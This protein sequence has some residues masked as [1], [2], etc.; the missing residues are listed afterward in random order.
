MSLRKSIGSALSE[1]ARGTNAGPVETRHSVQAPPAVQPTPLLWLTVLSLDA[2]TVAALWQRLFA[3]A[4]RVQ[5]AAGVTALLALVV[6]LIYVADRALD[7]LKV[8]ARG[9]EAARHIFYRRHLWAFAVPFCAGLSLAAWMALMQLD[10]RTFRHGVILLL[11]VGAYLFAVHKLA[12]GRNWLPKEMLVGV[13]FALGTCFPVWERMPKGLPLLA[14]YLIFT[15]LCWMNCAAIEFEEWKRL[16]HQ[17][18]GTPHPWTVWMGRHFAVL[19]L[20]IGASALSLL[21]FGTGHTTWQLVTSELLSALAFGA[22]WHKGETLSIDRF[23]V[24]MD[25]ALFTPALFLL[26]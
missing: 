23:R 7:T 8:P 9:A 21:V 17:K 25:V 6:W 20:F 1:G 2:P 15:V 11:A 4:F 13:L 26:I 12:R 18:F 19:C 22:I 24:L 14:P 3:R 5:L 16:R 10:V